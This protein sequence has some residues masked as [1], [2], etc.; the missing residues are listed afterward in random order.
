MNRE[1]WIAEATTSTSL[2]DGQAEALYRRASGEGRQSAA[3]AMGTSGSNLDNL[4]RAARERIIHARNLLSLAAAISAD[5]DE[6]A[7][8]IG[9]CSEC[10]EGVS[11][12]KPDPADDSPLDEVR[13]VCPECHEG[14]QAS[15]PQNGGESA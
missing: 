4:E 5:G 3:D 8:P 12:L 15:V 9:T 10:D 13:M 14:R 11:S 2:T 7:V 1:E 6:W